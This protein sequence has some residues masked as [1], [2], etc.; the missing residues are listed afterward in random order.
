M[1]TAGG[2]EVRAKAKA[3]AKEGAMRMDEKRKEEV[4]TRER[5]GFGS[6]GFFGLSGSS[7]CLI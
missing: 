5:P 3:K 6:S 2:W 4:V 7:V 1:T